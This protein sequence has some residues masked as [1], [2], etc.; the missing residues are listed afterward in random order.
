[1]CNNAGMTIQWGNAQLYDMIQALQ[2]LKVVH[3]NRRFNWEADRLAKEGKKRSNVFA[4]W[5]I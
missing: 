5:T 1:M 2:Y 3:I 4:G